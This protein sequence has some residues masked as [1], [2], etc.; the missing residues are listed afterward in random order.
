MSVGAGGLVLVGGGSAGMD[1]SG[2]AV[3]V[4]VGKGGGSLVGVTLPIPSAAQAANITLAGMARKAR[5]ISRRV[6]LAGF[7]MSI[8]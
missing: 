8:S 4:G 3:L 5:K 6:S 2:G 7:F 1:V